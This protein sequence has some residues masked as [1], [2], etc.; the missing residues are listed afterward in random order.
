MQTEREREKDCWVQGCTVGE[1]RIHKPFPT[2]TAHCLQLKLCNELGYAPARF[3][4]PKTLH[5]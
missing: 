1:T 5:S 2:W 3:G 4:C